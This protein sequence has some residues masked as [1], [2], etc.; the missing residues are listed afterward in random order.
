MSNSL[1]PFSTLPNL[2]QHLWF[3]QV[4]FR[5]GTLGHL[6]ELRD[7]KVSQIITWLQ[8]WIRGFYTRREYKKLQDQR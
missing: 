8:S 6:E 1:S 2:T 5:A 7:D 3:A 4:F